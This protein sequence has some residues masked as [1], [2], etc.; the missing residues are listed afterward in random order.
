MSD[1]LP[2]AEAVTLDDAPAVDST[3][4]APPPPPSFDWYGVYTQ[5]QPERVALRAW[6]DV[7]A[8]ARFKHAFGIT[9]TPHA[10]N[11]V[12]SA[13]YVPTAKDLDLDAVLSVTNPPGSPPSA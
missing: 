13:D 4:P 3:P 8:I 12:K 5:S 9:G 7:D 11:V 10:I 2:T 1:E 6:N